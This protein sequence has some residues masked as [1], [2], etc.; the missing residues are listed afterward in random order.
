[1]R[2]RVLIRLLLGGGAFVFLLSADFALIQI[3]ND[4]VDGEFAFGRRTQVVDIDGELVDS[5]S[6]MERLYR[7][8]DSKTVRAILLN[9]ES[10]GCEAAV[11]QEIDS[12]IRP[13]REHNHKAVVAFMSQVGASD[14][15]YAA[16]GAD[17]MIANPG[18][19]RAKPARFAGRPALIRSTS[20]CVT[21]MDLDRRY[22]TS[23][24]V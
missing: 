22:L 8:E 13:L 1:M 9:I 21:L 6:S 24:T 11:S 16:R 5:R 3:L 4:S 10:T 20:Q 19:F 2:N 12:E 23:D 14:E 15:D 18:V 7:I 17:Q